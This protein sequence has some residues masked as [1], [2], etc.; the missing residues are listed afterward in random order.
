MNKII[1]ESLTVN[2]PELLAIKKFRIIPK[3]RPAE[4]RVQLKLSKANPSIKDKY[5][6][7][8]SKSPQ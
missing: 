4:K 6:P 1:E 2:C 8:R 3:G 7:R 5:L